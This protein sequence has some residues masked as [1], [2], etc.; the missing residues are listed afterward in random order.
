MWQDESWQTAFRDVIYWYLNSNFSPRGIDAGIILT[1]AA[2]ERLSFE[3]SVR[4]K[5]LRTMEDFKNLR[6]SDKFRLFFSSLDIPNEVP[7]NLST[8]QELSRQFNWLD[9]PHA[10]TEVRNSLVHP[11][12]KSRGKTDKAIF[13]AWNLGLWYLEMSILRLCGYE[14]TYSNRLHLGKWIG[15]VEEVPWKK[16]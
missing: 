15:E 9:A 5:K 4:S 7:S 6:A 2:I 10:F 3:Y 16:S 1:Q 12:H 11:E 14:G 13:E 8:L